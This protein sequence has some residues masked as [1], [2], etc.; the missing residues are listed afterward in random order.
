MATFFAYLLVIICSQFVQAISGI[1]AGFPVAM[2]LAR[3][4]VSFRTKVAGY[5]CGV[6]G[7]LSSVAFGYGAFR[8]LL[9]SDSYSLGVFLASIVPLLPRILNDFQ[10]AKNVSKSRQDMLNTLRK[11]RDRQTVTGLEIKSHTA[12]WSAVV[13]ELTGVL[14]AVTW[15]AQ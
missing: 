13:G 9:G 5:I 12:H 11:T 6:F 15:Y 10:L 7:V 2:I 4:S 8:L 14:A 1:L 3:T